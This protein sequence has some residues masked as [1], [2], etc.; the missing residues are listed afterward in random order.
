MIKEAKTYKVEDELQGKKAKARN[1][2]ERFAYARKNLLCDDAR[3]SKVSSLAKMSLERKIAE[4]I[5]WVEDTQAAEVEEL[6]AKKK[7]LKDLFVP[8]SQGLLTHL[9]AEGNSAFQ[10]GDFLQA[11]TLFSEAMVLEPGKYVIYS[12]LHDGFGAVLGMSQ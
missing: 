1:S 9:A 7:A 4:T 11:I 3:M 12:A 8:I 5:C 10:E 6:E 2:L